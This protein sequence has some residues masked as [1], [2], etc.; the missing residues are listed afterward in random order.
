MAERISEETAALW[1][2][3]AGKLKQISSLASDCRL[4][5]VLK[6]NVTNGKA[7]EA[8]DALEEA[9]SGQ[10]YMF[11][12]QPEWTGGDSSDPKNTKMTL[13]HIARKTF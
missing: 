4:I 7:L 6:L 2:E 10:S 13:P 9:I 11:T 12:P 1:S 8:I 3:I 5:L